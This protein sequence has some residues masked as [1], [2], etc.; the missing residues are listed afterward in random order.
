MIYDQILRFY[1]TFRLITPWFDEKKEQWRLNIQFYVFSVY[2]FMIWCGNKYSSQV[3][4]SIVETVDIDWKPI[5]KKIN[6]RI[7]TNIDKI[8]I[9]WTLHKKTW[10]IEVKY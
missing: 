9:D 1:Y 3:L 6:Q 8:H 10:R 5:K 7:T 2:N 4:T